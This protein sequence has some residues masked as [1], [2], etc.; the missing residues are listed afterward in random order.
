MMT[1]LILAI[2][3]L[4]FNFSFAQNKQPLTHERM[5]AMKRVG[6]PEISP[7][8]KWVV[9]TVTEAS[10]DEKENISDLWLAPSDGTSKPRRITSGKS[11]E[12]GYKWSRIQSKLYSVPNAKAM[13]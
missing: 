1:R 13:K 3:L 10:Y 11:A 9:F 12:S 4:T 7:D 6:A 5:W 8:G 2:T